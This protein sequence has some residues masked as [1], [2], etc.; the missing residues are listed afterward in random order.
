MLVEASKKKFSGQK[1]FSKGLNFKSDK[2]EPSEVLTL[3][4]VQERQQ[5]INKQQSQI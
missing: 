4:L 1:N 2:S 3:Q 5:K